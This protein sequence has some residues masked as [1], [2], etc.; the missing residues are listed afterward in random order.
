[1]STKF[2][3]QVHKDS[4]VWSSP[5]QD[6][7]TDMSFSPKCIPVSGRN[8]TYVHG[9]SPNFYM[10]NFLIKYIN[11]PWHPV[12]FSV[13]SVFWH[14]G[15]VSGSIW[16]LQNFDREETRKE[17]EFWKKLL[18]PVRSVMRTTCHMHIH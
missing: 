13:F 9:V 1:M 18:Q 3:L 6:T 12:C 15:Y 16:D 8:E 2:G 4:P 11:F 10:S 7:L 5:L 14:S 17:R